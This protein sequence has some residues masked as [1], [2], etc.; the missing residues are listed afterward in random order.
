MGRAEVPRN[1]LCH[2][3]HLSLVMDKTYKTFCFK[4][5]ICKMELLPPLIMVLWLYSALK[6][7][8]ALYM[9]NTIV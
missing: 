1:K 2:R 6:I 5:P 8:S 4:F 7:I 9:P 3:V